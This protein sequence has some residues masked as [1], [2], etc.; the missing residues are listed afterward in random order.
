MPTAHKPAGRKTLII[1][2]VVLHCDQPI[3]NDIIE[4]KFYCHIERSRNEAKPNIL[5]IFG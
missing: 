1:P 2:I 5:W 3:T 4:T